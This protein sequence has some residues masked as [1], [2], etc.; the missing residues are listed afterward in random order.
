MNT[1]E[2]KTTE[3]FWTEMDVRDQAYHLLKARG[4][5]PLEVSQDV[6]A[7]TCQE[8]REKLKGGK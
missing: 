4:Q 5:R 6:W 8:V 1:E 7:A 3:Q 2:V